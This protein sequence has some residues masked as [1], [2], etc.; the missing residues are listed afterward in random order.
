MVGSKGSEHYLTLHFTLLDT[1]PH[2]PAIEK[3]QRHVK[4]LNEKKRTGIA[5]KWKMARRQLKGS[6]EKKNMDQSL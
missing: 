2:P 6:G 3:W 5:E 4:V 1:E